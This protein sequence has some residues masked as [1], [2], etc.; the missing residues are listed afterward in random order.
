MTLSVLLVLVTAFQLS[1]AQVRNSTQTLLEGTSLNI[2]IRCGLAKSYP[3]ISLYWKINGA[4]YNL[5]HLPEPF[6]ISARGTDLVIPAPDRRLDGY[7]LQCVSIQWAGTGNSTVN[8]TLGQITILDVLHPNEGIAEYYYAFEI[9]PWSSENTF[10]KLCMLAKWSHAVE[11]KKCVSHVNTALLVSPL[12]PFL[13]IPI[14]SPLHAINCVQPLIIS[15]HH[16]LVI[17]T[18]PYSWQ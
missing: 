6:M 18:T 5:L 1:S 14:T 12:P 8:E 10:H 11:R 13:P 4:L 7:T 3:S 2:P 15:L 17:I 16:I 9:S